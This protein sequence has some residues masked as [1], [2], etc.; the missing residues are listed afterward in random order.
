M[1]SYSSTTSR[2]R[3]SSFWGETE[4]RC[5]TPPGIAGDA[6]VT[7]INPDPENR[8]FNYGGPYGVF[9]SLERGYRYTTPLPPTDQEAERL[10]ATFAGRFPAKRIT[11]LQ[12]SADLP[13][14]IP[15]AGKLRFEAWAFVPILGAIRGTDDDPT[16]LEYHNDST[17][18]PW[19]V[20]GNGGTF[21]MEPDWHTPR[22]CLWPGH[23][24][25]D[26][27]EHSGD[28]GR[29]RSD[30]SPGTGALERPLE[31]TRGLRVGRGPRTGLEYR[32][33]AHA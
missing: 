8:P 22:L 33:V 28:R 2:L 3:R 23:L 27:R 30:Q 26:P 20:G 16:N 4:L 7:V 15:G 29:P 11:E 13:F 21:F 25:V 17:A 31:S 32:R 24:R 9:G 5:L 14:E 1:P 19:F 12:E 18:V 6:E 10:V